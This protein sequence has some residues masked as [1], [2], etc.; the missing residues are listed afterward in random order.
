MMKSCDFGELTDLIGE[1]SGD[2]E[3]TLLVL[4]A[5]LSTRFDKSS[6]PCP[7]N[8]E[9]RFGNLRNSTQY[10]WHRPIGLGLLGAARILLERL[11]ADRGRLRI[12][13]AEGF[14]SGKGDRAYKAAEKRARKKARDEGWTSNPHTRDATMMQEIHAREIGHVDQSRSPG[15]RGCISIL[16]GLTD[17]R[18]PPP[19]LC[20][21]AP[22]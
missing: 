3:D 1:F 8:I 7:R 18:I 17:E 4:E 12:H 5:P 9:L 6:N 19:V 11:L 16:A 22:G 2:G 21:R 10:S 15:L 13:L 20:L 14:I